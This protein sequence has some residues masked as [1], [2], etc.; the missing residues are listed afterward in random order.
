MDQSLV[1]LIRERF[2]YEKYLLLA[3]APENLIHPIGQCLFP[4]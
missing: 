3:L 1:V 4:L 2:V